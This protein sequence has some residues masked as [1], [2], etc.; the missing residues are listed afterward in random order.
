[1][2]VFAFEE[3]HGVLDTNVAR[4]LARRSGRRLKRAAAQQA[5]DD[6]VPAGESWWWNQ[7]LLD[8][9]AR[10]C[11]ARTPQCAECPLRA[12]C[13]WQGGIDGADDPAVG[14]A[15]VAGGQSRFAGSDRQGRGRLVAALRL[16]P[17]AAAQVAPIA[18]WPDDQARADRVAAGLVADGLAVESD[19]GLTLP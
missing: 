12:G 15:G 16:G 2:L 10:L 9:G 8:L 6:A 19:G 1:V 18:G 13:A 11:R 5:A 17:V 3:D 7:A 14:S 4:I